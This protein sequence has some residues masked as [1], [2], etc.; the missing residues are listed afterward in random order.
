ME[1]EQYYKTSGVC[2]D[3]RKI[4]R[5]CL[6]ICLKGDNFNGNTF[7]DEALKQGAKYVI[8]DELE[9]ANNASI[10]YVSNA[11]QYLQ[12][13]ANHHRNKFDIP[14]IGITGS[15]GKTSTKELINAVLSIKY[16]V[17]AT[18]GNLNNHIGVPLTLLQLSKKHEIAIIEMGASKPHDIQ[19]LCDIAEPNYGIITNIG[20]AHLEGFKN[21]EGVLKTKRELY[22]CVEKNHGSL[23]VNADDDILTAILPKNTSR[24]SYGEKL[25]ATISGTLDCLSPFIEMTW[26]KKGYESDSL[27]MKMI[28]KYNFYNYLAAIAFG[29]LFELTPEQINQG[30]LSYNPTNNRSQVKETQHNTL[31]LD[32][33]NANPSSMKSALESFSLIENDSKFVILGDMLELGTD[34]ILEHQKILELLEEKNITGFTV[35]PIFEG[36]ESNYLKERFKTKEEARAYLQSTQLNGKFILLKGSRGIGLETL[37]NYL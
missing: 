12:D 21:F 27:K 28:G 2:T 8:V 14:I 31:I 16:H 9:Y 7:A 18:A 35:G 6:F 19:E 4:T 23:I 33:Y 36:I 3:T 17:L 13:L 25:D 11:L 34:S 10:Y 5:D 15:N 32:C 1:F 37:E 20:K 22:D 29:N 26:R 24:S 30:I